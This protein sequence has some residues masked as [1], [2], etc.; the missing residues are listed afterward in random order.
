MAL[1]TTLLIGQH[2]KNLLSHWMALRLPF[3]L[4]GVED[5]PSHWT[6][7][8]KPPFSLGGVEDRPSHWT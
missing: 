7:R 6:S 4:Y 3:S 2:A 1:K 5:C 8:Q